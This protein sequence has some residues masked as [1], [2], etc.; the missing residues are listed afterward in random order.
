MKN[1][2]ELREGKRL[3]IVQGYVIDVK[4]RGDANMLLFK[5]DTT[6]PSSDLIAVAAWAAAEGQT[7]PDMKEMTNNLKGRFVVCVV[8][9]RQKERDGRLFTNYDLQYIVKPPEK[10]NRSA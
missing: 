6:D 3:G 9:I 2:Y 7:S 10:I 1:P 8:L 4:D 5:V